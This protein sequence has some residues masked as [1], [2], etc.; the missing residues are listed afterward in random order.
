MSSCHYRRETCRLCGGGD[1]E[2]VFPLAPTPFADSY[3]G[4]ES[5]DKVQEK[6]PL[7]L[8]FCKSCSHLQLLDVIDPEVLYGDYIYFTA[9]S[10]GLVE[11]FREY[12][13]EVAGVVEPPDGSLAVDIGSNDG[14][15]LK[16]FKNRAMK[17]LGIDPAREIAKKAT[18]S[19]VETIPAFFN[20]EL[21]SKIR[22]EYGP[23]TIVT[24]NNVFA[25]ADNLA[26]LA[27]GIRELL[28]RDGAFVFEVSYLVDMVQN[29]VFDWVYHEH[30]CYHSV[31]PLDAFF[32]RHGM[33][34]FDVKRVPTKG[35]S[36]RG[37]AQF[38]DGPRPISPAVGELMKLEEELKFDC[39]ETFKDFSKEIGKAKDEL[40]ELLSRLKSEGK[41]IA[42]YGASATV[43]T[44]I[45]HFDI[46]RFLDFII[47]D[48]PSRQNLFS[49]GH[50][51]PILS[52]QALYERN[53]DYVVVLAWRF[54]EPIMK[55]HQRYL[56]EGGHFI[57]PLPMIEVK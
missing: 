9:S 16:Y 10:P 23:A 47:D 21:G 48:E 4:K 19:G 32:R 37:F 53:P 24:A 29:K 15:L 14:T 22:K 31:K 45:Y 52:P 36:L 20:A 50:H 33:E 56:S 41:V 12:A 11:H 17:V 57:V 28:D 1:L 35:G 44:L 27:E 30:L 2:L 54:S 55:K 5:L 6:F 43:T 39:P 25:H 13:D 51:I 38:L 40:F 18:D 49:P 42:G 3:I 34:L 26:D 46:G 7:D 8:Y